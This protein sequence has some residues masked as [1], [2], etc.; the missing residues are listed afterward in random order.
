MKSEISLRLVA[1]LLS[2]GSEL[3]AVISMIKSGKLKPYITKN[4]A[5]RRYGRKNVEQWIDDGLITPRKDGGHSAG[6]RIDRVEVESVIKA[7]EL[8]QSL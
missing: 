4:E 2:R 8:L 5:F 7:R 1:L 6:W 3:G